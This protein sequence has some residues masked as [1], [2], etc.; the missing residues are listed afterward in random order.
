MISKK[1]D[2]LLDDIKSICINHR[3]DNWANSW[4]YNGNQSPSSKIQNFFYTC[5]EHDGTIH[6]QD[7]DGLSIEIQYQQNHRTKE[8]YYRIDIKEKKYDIHNFWLFEDKEFLLV[9]TYVKELIT[10]QYQKIEK[11]YQL[12]TLS[13]GAYMEKQ[14]DKMYQTMNVKLRKQKLLKISNG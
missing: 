13:N 4:Q 2:K 6:Y 7:F 5:I 1:L 9:E 14:P 12:L 3:C 8:Y 11:F 10:L